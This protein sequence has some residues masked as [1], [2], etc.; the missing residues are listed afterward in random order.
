MLSLQEQVIAITQQKLSSSIRFLSCPFHSQDFWILILLIISPS[1]GSILSQKYS[2]FL[3][4]DFPIPFPL[5]IHHMIIFSILLLFLSVILSKYI[6]PSLSQAFYIGIYLILNLYWIQLQDIISIII[7][8]QMLLQI[9]NSY[10]FHST[11]FPFGSIFIPGPRI[12]D[13]LSMKRSN[14]RVTPLETLSC[15]ISS[16]YTYPIAFH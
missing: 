5:G 14:N 12:Q 16:F 4:Q 11:P 13:F 1:L 3:Q 10:Y 6:S 9:I 2:G 7:S 15:Y 8:L